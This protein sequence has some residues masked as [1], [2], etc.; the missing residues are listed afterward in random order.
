MQG[1]FK[2]QNYHPGRWFK[3]LQLLPRVVARMRSQASAR[4]A[5]AEAERS[6][7]RKIKAARDAGC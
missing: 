7:R 3:L 1:M 4:I 2:R 5:I 6:V